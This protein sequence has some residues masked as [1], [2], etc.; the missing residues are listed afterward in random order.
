MNRMFKTLTSAVAWRIVG[1]SCKRGSPA[2]YLT[3]F[4]GPGRPWDLTPAF[5]VAPGKDSV[6]NHSQSILGFKN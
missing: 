3:A 2:S 4:S 1:H 5:G 6:Q